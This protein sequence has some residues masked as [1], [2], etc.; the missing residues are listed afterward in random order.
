[1]ELLILVDFDNIA[2]LIQNRGL[3]YISERI[4]DRLEFNEINSY[5]R[6][7]LRLYGGWYEQ[8]IPT[9]TA[10]QLQTDIQLNFP[11]RMN[12]TNNGNFH[13]A[14]IIV[15]MA[16][17]LII[18]PNNHLFSTYRQRGMPH[19]LRCYHP[20][21]LGCT[22]HSCPLIDVHAFINT[23]RCN[24][25]CCNIRSQ[26]MIYRGEQKLVDTMVM[27]DLIYLASDNDYDSVIIVSSDDDFWPGIK[28]AIIMGTYIVHIHTRNRHTPNYYSSNI[29]QSNYSQRIM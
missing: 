1:M 6:I 26:D 27:C 16:L 17:T 3:V 22:N 7:R 12:I 29:R 15:E 21:S 10:Q 25:Q 14:I 13:S 23:G 5:R 2:R 19:G 4:I 20:N 8:N 28:T 9:R 11:R 24:T 18:D